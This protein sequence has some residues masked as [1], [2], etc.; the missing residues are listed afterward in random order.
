MENAAAACKYYLGVH[1]E[2]FFKKNLGQK[3]TGNKFLT[4]C[5]SEKQYNTVPKLNCHPVQSYFSLNPFA[6]MGLD[7]SNSEQN[8]TI[9][10]TGLSPKYIPISGKK[11]PGVCW[12]EVN[13]ISRVKLKQAG[14]STVEGNL[15][16]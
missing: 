2:Y 15:H 13:D 14:T 6:T 3:Y 10:L 8:R 16:F 4:F 5:K 12:L 9:N 11:Y 7:W 1:C